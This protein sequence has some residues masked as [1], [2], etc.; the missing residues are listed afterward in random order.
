MVLAYDI[1]SDPDRFEWS[2]AAVLLAVVGLTVGAISR[3]SVRLLVRP[4]AQLQEGLQD[5]CAGRLNQIPVHRTGDEIEAL[6][7]SFNQMISALAASNAALAEYHRLLEEKISQRTEQLEHALHIATT[8]SQT[9]SEFL[10][11]MSHELRTPMSG[12]IG[13][14]DLVL[15]SPLSADQREQILTAHNCAYSL[16]AL[17]NDV[18]D[19]S[20]IE[21]GRMV[22][23]EIPLD[24]RQLVAECAKAHQLK[25]RAKGISLTWQA[26]DAV[27]R[28]ILGDPLR[29]RQ[30]LNNLL[31]NAV[32]F[33]SEGHVR[34]SVS[35]QPAP[36][37]THRPHTL[38]LVVSDTGPGIAPEKQESIF[39]KFTQADGSISRK[40]GGT[41]LGLAITRKLTEV[42]G[43]RIL[44]DSKPGSGSSFTVLL[45]CGKVDNGA[46]ESAPAAGPAHLE[47]ARILVV[48]DNR[49]NQK[50]VVSLLRKKGFTAD[51]ANNGQEALDALQ[52]RSYGLVLMD[53]QMPVLDG[54][55]AT[56]R[57]RTDARF[58]WL[59]IVAMTARAMS[60]DRERCLRA[61]MNDYLAKPVDHKHLLS[62]VEKYL[63][64]VDSC[65]AQQPAL[66]GELVH[67][68]LQLS[69]QRLYE[70]RQSC[71]AGDLAA[72]QIE[73]RKLRAA[74]EVINAEGVVRF[75]SA[76]EDAGARAD[77]QLV[78]QSLL[79][80]D[81]AIREL[82][83]QA[84]P[85]AG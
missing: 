56:R 50:V 23:E 34:V 77:L 65:P 43:G 19:L 85:V 84:A 48:E 12:V 16:L 75:A 70:L 67:L 73:A 28:Q 44:L 35:L 14:L 36:G 47:S 64:Q 18:L 55:E 29:I 6:G 71:E 1:S 66:S 10:A 9:K 79:H 30:I 20:K 8:A 45:P 53:V 7:S 52:L 3:F 38:R 58:S 15:D 42:H 51:V 69:P 46:G 32:K 68:F 31:S 49:I 27:P 21:A 17:L 40:F 25:A 37:D 59:P 60:G 26:E 63:T 41:G 81:Q 24:I 83:R 54:L 39:E 2:K 82:G 74:A 61:G 57:I 72:I 4:L 22:L 80:L 62:L 13:M 11:N 33:T 78:Q 5:A 76:L